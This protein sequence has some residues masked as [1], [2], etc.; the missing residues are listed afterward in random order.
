MDEKREKIRKYIEG[1]DIPDELKVKELAIVDDM[2]LLTPEVEIALAK[3]IGE[4]F[5]KQ[6]ANAGITDIPSDDGVEEARKAFESESAEA[7]KDLESD[8]KIVDD[9]LKSIQETSEEIQK[10]SLQSSLNA[11]N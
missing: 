3:L 10:V 1:S 2:N 8:M 6:I 11:D 4:E 7:E 5:D 9:N